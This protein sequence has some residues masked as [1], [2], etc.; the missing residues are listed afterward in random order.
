MLTS[1]CD[2]LMIQNMAEGCKEAMQTEV[3]WKC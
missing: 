2:R 1:A 3:A